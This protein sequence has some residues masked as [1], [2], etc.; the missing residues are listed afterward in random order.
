MKPVRAVLSVPPESWSWDVPVK[1]EAEP[2]KA[3]PE[4]KCFKK[5]NHWRYSRSES[6]Q[7]W[8]SSKPFRSTASV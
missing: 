5:G 3:Q 6:D 8:C 2:T 4:W 7:I 1:K